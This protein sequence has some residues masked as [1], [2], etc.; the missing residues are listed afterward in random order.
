MW[1]VLFKNIKNEM[2][3]IYNWV[4]FVTIN[5]N[6]VYNLLYIETRWKKKNTLCIHKYTCAY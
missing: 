3:V 4:D 2:A 6:S 5:F 1:D